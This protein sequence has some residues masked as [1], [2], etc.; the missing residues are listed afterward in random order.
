[1][2]GL[3]NR[4]A[5]KYETYLPNGKEIKHEIIFGRAD[6][7]R[8]FDPEK[9]EE[10]FEQVKEKYETKIRGMNKNTIKALTWEYY[11]KKDPLEYVNLKE[12]EE[13]DSEEEEEEITKE[14]ITIVNPKVPHG[15]TALLLGGS[16]CGKTTL[17]VQSLNNLLKEYKDRYDMVIIMSQT[18][19]S[20]PLR[21]LKINNKIIIFNK[22]I[23]ELI[24]FLIKIQMATSVPKDIKDP[25]KGYETRY[26]ILIVLDDI[27]KLKNPMIDELILVARNYGISTIISTQKVTGLSP[28]A[29]ESIHTN[30]I[31]GGRNPETRRKIIEK[32]LRGYIIE[33][34][35]KKA[36][37]MDKWVRD[38]TALGDGERKLIKINGLNDKMSIHTI[39]K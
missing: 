33:S 21:D 13:S 14:N 26:S 39:Q 35:I 34:G 16:C 25:T 36:D 11:Q 20:I 30:Y 10:A 15:T 23:P 17:L 38:N 31:F 18:P 37:D 24:S 3:V 2:D 1:M 27:T 12:E 32:Y 29:R 19:T 22:F 6:A 4:H 7:K 9:L 8:M 5:I 28:A